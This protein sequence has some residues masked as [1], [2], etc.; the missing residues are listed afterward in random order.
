MVALTATVVDDT[1][2]CELSKVTE[3]GDDTDEV[4]ETGP[5]KPPT[6]VRLKVDELPWRGYRVIDGGLGGD[7]LK[8]AGVLK[9]HT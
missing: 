8:S 3:I 1:E 5:L 7:M 4:R 6:P 2:G 9:S